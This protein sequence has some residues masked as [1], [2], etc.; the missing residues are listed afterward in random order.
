MA[1]Y[2]ENNTTTAGVPP[3]SA[4]MGYGNQNQNRNPNRTATASSHTRNAA[5]I[6]VVRGENRNLRAPSLQ[7]SHQMPRV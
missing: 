5:D 4:T 1:S 7:N 6:A 2:L 3:G